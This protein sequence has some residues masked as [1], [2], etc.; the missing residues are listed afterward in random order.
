MIFCTVSLEVE[1]YGLVLQT[2]KAYSLVASFR[3]IREAIVVQIG[4]R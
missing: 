2:P 4:V 1:G 3:R